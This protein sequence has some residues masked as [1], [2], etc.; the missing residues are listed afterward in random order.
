[1]KAVTAH[2]TVFD[3]CD[4]A[5]KVTRTTHAIPGVEPV[6]FSLMS[7]TLHDYGVSQVTKCAIFS[8]QQPYESSVMASSTSKAN[9]NDNPQGKI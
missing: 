2:V 1:M 8:R 3:K 9:A 5:A 4:A 6:F 7:I